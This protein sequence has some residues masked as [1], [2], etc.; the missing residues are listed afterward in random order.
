MIFS[1][2]GVLTAFGFSTVIFLSIEISYFFAT[3]R[4]VISNCT[5]LVSDGFSLLARPSLALPITA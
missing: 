2:S 1:F 3:S 5:V 4:T